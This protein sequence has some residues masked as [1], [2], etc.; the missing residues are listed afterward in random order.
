[1]NEIIESSDVRFPKWS[2]N[3][4]WASFVL[5]ALNFVFGVLLLLE[6]LD[7]GKFHQ[8]VFVFGITLMVISVITAVLGALSLKFRNRGWL[9]GAAVPFAISVMVS[10]V[11]MWGLLVK[12]FHGMGLF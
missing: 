8:A 1:M 10:L 4:V 11:I 5:L 7:D 3:L 6:G 9:V 12:L 2:R